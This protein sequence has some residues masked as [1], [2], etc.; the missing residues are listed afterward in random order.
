MVCVS[1]N[2]ATLARDLGGLLK[3]GYEV[4]TVQPVDLFPH[5]AHIESVTLLQKK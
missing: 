3:G 5:T 1:C 2:T 4:R